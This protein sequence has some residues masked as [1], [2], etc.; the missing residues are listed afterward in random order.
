MIKSKEKE[1]KTPKRGATSNKVVAV[2][3]EL[4]NGAGEGTGPTIE[5]N[6]SQAFKKKKTYNSTN[7]EEKVHVFSVICI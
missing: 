2:D 5:T 6:L 7:E 3:D 4:V 1:I